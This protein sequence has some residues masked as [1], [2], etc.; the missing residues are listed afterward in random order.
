MAN[1]L[2]DGSPFFVNIEEKLFTILVLCLF[3]LE[4]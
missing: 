1:Y 2:K 3:M 4:K